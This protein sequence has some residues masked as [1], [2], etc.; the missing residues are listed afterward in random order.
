MSWN[1]RLKKYIF[2][3]TIRKVDVFLLILVFV[4]TIVCFT[5]Q[6]PVKEAI[7]SKTNISLGYCAK[8]VSDELFYVVDNGHERLICFDNGGHIRFSIQN[9]SDKNGELSYIDDFAIT[10]NGIYISASQW[11]GMALAR[12]AILF[13]DQDGNYVKTVR[14]RDYSSIK[15][16]KHRFYGVSEQNGVLQYAECLDDR[17]VIGN[18]EIPYVNAFNAVSDVVFV[19]TTVYVLDKDGTIREYSDGEKEGNIVFSQSEKERYEIVPYK[20][21]ADKEGRIYFTDIKNNEVRLVD[22]ENKTSNKVNESMGSLTVGISNT[23]KMLLLDDDGLHV[24]DHD[25]EVVYFDLEK[26]MKEIC[27]QIIWLMAVMIAAVIGIL[28]LSR[29]I[30]LL[31][32][33]KFSPSGILCFWVILAVCIVSI[34]LCSLLMN[35]FAAKYRSKIVEQLECAAY[36]I[37]NQ[38][39][40]DDIE[41]IEE[42]GGFGGSSYHRLCEIMEKS[43]S[44]DIEFYDQIYCNILKLS[45]DGKTGYAVAYL[46]QSIGSYFPLDEVE[47]KELQTVYQTGKTVQNN[48]VEDI[49]GTYLSVKVPIFNEEGQVCGAVATGAE[50]Y[51]IED[52]LQNLVRKIWLSIAIILMLVWLVS[53]EG[54]SFISNYSYYKKERKKEAERTAF[55]AHII[56]LLIFLVFAAYNMTAAFLPVYLLRQSDIFTGKMKEIAGALPI[57]VN[58]FLIGIMSLFCARLVE[59]FGLRKIMAFAAASSFVGNFVIYSFSGFYPAMIGLILDGI[60]VG[61]ITNAVYVLVT[62]VKEERDRAWGLRTYNS[63]YLSGINFGMMFGSILAVN[64]GQHKVFGIVAAVWL[65]LLGLTWAMMHLG[66]PALETA[67][68]NER[69]SEMKSSTLREFILNRS[70]LSFV[71]FI[72]NP[73]IVFGSFVF[74]YVPIFCDVNGLNETICSILIMLYSQVAVLGTDFLTKTVSKICK[75]YGMYLSLV[76]NITALLVFSIIPGIKTMIV[77]LILMG[78]SSAFGKPVQQNYYL[79]LKSTK[80]YGDDKAMGIYNFTENIGESLGPVIFG[81]LSSSARFVASSTAFC[82]VIGFLMA[83][84]YLISKKELKDEK[85]GK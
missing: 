76:I 46:D 38:V 7:Q 66:I 53:V 21:A 77:A 65:I 83:V 78:I 26:P 67:R 30:M 70:V 81:R 54:F 24:V 15:T 58:I 3:E 47:T 79:N 49:S 61:L 74:Y 71:V 32:R 4:L 11:D 8:S 72:Q 57:T 27:F 23:G 85:R 6:M 60:G 22:T 39:Q 52:I 56:R 9:L 43:F 37:A 16:N 73:Y 34:I 42:T 1:D 17:I 75:H 51:I 68:G 36:M 63:A 19:G 2:S 12:E 84:H 33:I 35:A 80:K 40:P 20:L 10:D 59:K 50:D 82:G 55:P 18:R 48:E 64:V 41:E 31:R 5:F 25:G 13:F 69:K 45:P 62:Y 29:L 44:A 14:N 28:L